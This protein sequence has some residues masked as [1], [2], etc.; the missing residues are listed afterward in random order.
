MLDHAEILSP[1]AERAALVDWV[2][3]VSQGRS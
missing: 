1:P 2:R 3:A